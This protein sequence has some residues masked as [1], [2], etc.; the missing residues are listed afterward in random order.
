MKRKLIIFS[1]MLIAFSL[2]CGC[3]YFSLPSEQADTSVN[4]KPEES[5]AELSLEASEEN[6]IE[7]S[8]EP[9]T[10][11]SIDTSS[12][13]SSAEESSEISSDSVSE[14]SAAGESSEV[15]AES[16][17]KEGGMTEY[18]EAVY[19]LNDYA[20][21]MEKSGTQSF[22]SQSANNNSPLIWKVSKYMTD[23]FNSDGS[24]E[25]VIQYQVGP[26]EA[27]GEQGI[28]L[29]I[30]KYDGN[31]YVSYKRTE[32][33]SSY[34]R[35]AGA[36]YAPHEIVDEL[37]V[38]DSGNLS[39][40]ATSTS[41]TSPVSAVYDIYHLNGESVVQ[42]YDL[43]V[44]KEAY[45]GMDNITDLSHAGFAIIDEFPY[46]YRFYIQTASGSQTYMTM[47]AGVGLHREILA[48]EP[49]PDFAVEDAVVHDME[50]NYDY[51]TTQINFCDIGIAEEAFTAKYAS[52]SPAFE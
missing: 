36:S 22:E 3:D 44:T 48:I 31:N 17:P 7:E 28:A 23:D 18:E 21:K 6:S 37:F 15:S 20:Q 16:S 29:E 5:S 8:S 45:P 49:Q 43:H 13:G 10:E 39:I 46:T 2:L 24:P 25:L 14:A 30:I 50:R 40:L 42:Q 11:S 32:D 52:G 26:T 12:A 41:G 27:C 4:S 33:F 19:Y 35:L 1:S 9:S 47:Q 38:D 34:I 51:D